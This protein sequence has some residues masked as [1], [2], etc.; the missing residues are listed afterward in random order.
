MTFLALRPLQIFCI[1]TV[2][3]VDDFTERPGPVMFE[4]ILLIEARIERI[5][6]L[7]GGDRCRARER[8]GGA[9]SGH[10][11]IT[12]V[13]FIAVAHRHL[14]CKRSKVS[15]NIVAS[16]RKKLTGSDPCGLLKIPVDILVSN[17]TSKHHAENTGHSAGC[18][19]QLY[20]SLVALESAL[21]PSMRERRQRRI[22]NWPARPALTPA[23]GVLRP[24]EFCYLADQIIGP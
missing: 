13:Q 18:R 21:L 9:S 2:V 12:P 20:H 4:R 11:E 23:G 10:D 22:R 6:L 5:R 7:R 3:D 17:S 24:V 15:S 19:E 14:P 16:S 8:A 1:H